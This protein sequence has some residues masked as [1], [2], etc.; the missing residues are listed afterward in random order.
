M[1]CPG[2][3]VLSTTM[4]HPH[5]NVLYNTRKY[6]ISSKNLKMGQKIK[7]SFCFY[8]GTC[9]VLSLYSL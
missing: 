3:I 1:F 5:D 8:L 4:F 2:I 7:I 6:E 9:I